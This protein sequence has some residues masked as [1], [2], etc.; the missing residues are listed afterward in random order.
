MKSSRQD[1][2]RFPHKLL[3][4]LSWAGSDPDRGRRAE[5]GWIA[6]VE[7]LIGK[8][9][10]NQTLDIKKNTLDFQQ[11]RQSNGLT[12][13]QRDGFSQRSQSEAL[14]AIRNTRSHPE[15]GPAD[16][17]SLDF[18]LLDPLQLKG[19]RRTTTPASAARCS[20]AGTGSCAAHSP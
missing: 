4:L 19:S 2:R 11:T 6:D 16:P 12:I 20:R 9:V 8:P 3:S 10:L 1:G 17:R 7:F 5:C 15:R 18:A 14:D 13:W